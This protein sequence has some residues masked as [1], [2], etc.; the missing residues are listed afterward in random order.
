MTH[1]GRRERSCEEVA[2]GCHEIPME[3]WP[4]EGPRSALWRPRELSY[5]WWRMTCRLSAA[6]WGVSKHM[7]M[8]RF[9]SL[10]GT[11]DQ[12][13]LSNL[14]V[15]EVIAR[16]AHRVT[17]TKNCRGKVFVLQSSAQVLLQP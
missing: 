5:I 8:L 7:Q 13:D 11:F 2:A 4:I 6:E 10:A 1:H 12:L 15:I 14:A 9:L 17:N 16:R 3:N